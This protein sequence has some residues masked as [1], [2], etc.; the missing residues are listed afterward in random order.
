MK[1]GSKAR[2]KPNLNQDQKIKMEI[3]IQMKMIEILKRWMKRR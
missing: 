2:S 3:K 1:S